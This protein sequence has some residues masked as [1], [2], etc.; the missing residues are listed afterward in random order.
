MSDKRRRRRYTLTEPELTWKKEIIHVQIVKQLTSYQFFN[1]FR[2]ESNIS[3]RSIAK[4]N[5]RV[6]SQL[7]NNRG[8]DRA[9]LGR[10]ENSFTKRGVAQQS[11]ERYKDIYQFLDEVRRKRIQLR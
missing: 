2:S 11:E 7:L 9:L 10:R 3:Y 1:N 4:W 8:D 6:K 5:R